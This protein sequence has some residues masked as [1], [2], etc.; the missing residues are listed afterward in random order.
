VKTETNLSGAWVKQAGR[1]VPAIRCVAS[2]DASLCDV[3]FVVDR[4]LVIGRDA[5]DGRIVVQDGRVSRMHAVIF[6]EAGGLR[7][8]DTGSRN[9]TFVDGVSGAE[10]VATGAV[11]RVGS[12]LFVATTRGAQAPDEAPEDGLVGLSPAFRETCAQVRRAARNDL[13]VLLLGESGAGKEGLARL[14]HRESGRQG[15]LVTANCA[16]LVGELGSAALFGHERGAF[17]GAVQARPGLFRSADGGTLFLDEL[18]ELPLDVQPR[19]LRVLEQREVVPVGGNRPIPVDV[20]VVAATHADLM[21]A[22]HEGRFRGDLYARL[23]GWPVAVPPLRSRP[24]DIPRLVRYFAGRSDAFEVSALESLIRYAWPFNVRELRQLV[25]R[26]ILD[27][28]CPVP[29]S[30]LPEAMRAIAST[31]TP[32]IPSTARLSEDGAS[33]V[34]SILPDAP[35]QPKGLKQAAATTRGQLRPRPEREVL[36]ELLTRHGWNVSEVA[37]LLDRDRKQIYR[38]IEQYAIRPPGES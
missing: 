17:T 2:P 32:V 28:G 37:R 22:V 23:C 10:L 24:E 38:W 9:G 14:I 29:M 21:L 16:T 11:L 20:R 36:V 1:D 19:L 18:A 6:P 3:L 13:P 31:P 27:A 30:A 7:V 26:L 8:R 15:E 35:L 4:P 5:G 12:T 25:T 34:R 33:N